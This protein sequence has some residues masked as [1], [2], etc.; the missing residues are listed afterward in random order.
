ML[1]KANSAIPLSYS[2]E[3]CQT[4]RRTWSATIP[5]CC[6]GHLWGT[7]EGQHT[8]QHQ[9]LS[10][11]FI[12]VGTTKKNTSTC[13]CTFFVLATRCPQLVFWAKSTTKDYITAKNNV[14]SVS[15]LLCTQVI[16][17][18]IIQKAQNQSWHKFTHKKTQTSKKKKKNTGKKKKNNMHGIRNI[19]ER[20]FATEA[21]GGGQNTRG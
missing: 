21:R 8:C 17:Q 13:T 2:R 1:L 6:L 20:F 4:C 5:Y 15:Y 11:Y 12:P 10:R 9:L 7:T 18:Q 16:K 14:L 3:A 19:Q